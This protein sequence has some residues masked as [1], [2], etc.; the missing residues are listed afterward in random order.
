MVGNTLEGMSIKKHLP[1]SR[2]LIALC[3]IAVRWKKGA[4]PMVVPGMR[5]AIATSFLFD[6]V[7]I[8]REKT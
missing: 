6:L 5:V 4:V 3:K 1:G 7:A 8:C 2:I